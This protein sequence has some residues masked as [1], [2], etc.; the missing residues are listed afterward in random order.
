MVIKISAIP[1]V[2]GSTFDLCS[3]VAGVD[4]TEMDMECVGQAWHSVRG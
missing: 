3:D 4:V 2:T 1:K